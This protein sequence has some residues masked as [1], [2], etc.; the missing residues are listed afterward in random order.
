M[1]GGS[2]V[3]RVGCKQGGKQW[4]CNGFCCGFVIGSRVVDLGR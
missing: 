1:Y 4:M 3:V 2:A